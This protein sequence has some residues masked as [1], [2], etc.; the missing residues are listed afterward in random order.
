MEI[1]IDKADF[2]FFEENET[3]L[4]KLKKSLTGQ[5]TYLGSIIYHSELKGVLFEENF[6]VVDFD[7][8]LRLFHN[9]ISNCSVSNRT[10]YE[11]SL[12]R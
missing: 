6:G 1:R 3:F 11:F 12:S 5:N 7:W 2:I 9:L 10:M 4:N 8:V